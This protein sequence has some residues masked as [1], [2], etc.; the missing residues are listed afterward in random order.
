M[1]LAIDT[2]SN[3]PGPTPVDP[4]VLVDQRRIA[5]DAAG[6]AVTEA[7]V[8]RSEWIKLRSVRST[9][10][11]LG[12]A[13]VVAVGFGAVFS[14]AGSGGRHDGI[15]NP[16]ALSLAGFHLSELIIGVVGVLLV[17]AEYSTGLIRTTLSAVTSRLSILRAKA[18][19]YAL[20]VLAI[21]TAGA[22]VAFFVGQ[23][24]YSG[25]A[26]SASITDPGALRVVVGTAVYCTGV[27]LLGIALGFLLRSTAGAIGVLFATL[28]LIPG[29]AGLLPWSWSD[30]L[31]KLLP[32]NAGEAFTSV[33]QAKDLLTPGVGLAV[34]AGWIAVLLAGAAF[35]LQRRDA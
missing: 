19:V 22:F 34:F 35:T 4:T 29:L 32:S 3:S 24:L 1:S 5:R 13:I 18:T 10:I 7:R 33:T 20:T 14:S 12:A 21:T 26:G 8:L 25:A 31:V 17:S 28:L 23:S 6:L 27:G 15:V 2:A 16:I 30:T 11:S 9:L